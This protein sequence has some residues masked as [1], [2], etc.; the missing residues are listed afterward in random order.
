MTHF[1][2]KSQEKYCFIQKVNVEV[3]T[4]FWMSYLID[5]KKVTNEQ[6]ISIFNELVLMSSNKNEE[7]YIFEFLIFSKSA[8]KKSYHNNASYTLKDIALNFEKLNT[9]H[10]KMKV[11]EKESKKH[12]EVFNTM[13]NEEFKNYFKF[14]RW[15]NH[16]S[17]SFEPE[18]YN[19]LELKELMGNI[20]NNKLVIRFTEK[21]N[22]DFKEKAKRALQIFSKQK[23]VDNFH[24]RNNHCYVSYD[25]KNYLK[26]WKNI[27]NNEGYPK[28]IENDDA[29]LRF[30]EKESFAI[31]IHDNENNTSGF[32]SSNESYISDIN[33]ARLYQS[34]ELARKAEKTL[35]NSGAIV[36]VKVKFEEVMHN[37]HN[38]NV[39]VLEKV[40]ST[41]EKEMLEASLDNDEMQNLAKKLLNLCQENNEKLKSELEK[42]LIQEN[43]KVEKLSKKQ[44]I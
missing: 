24:M 43:N 25:F 31:F 4:L 29:M 34:E 27:L 19:P 12:S 8:I 41:K 15:A 5:T 35:T 7:A 39:S 38:I 13:T 23:F 28:E 17:Y 18:P 3:Q 6:V 22:L 10:E 30:N 44:K 37:P 36:K 32:L 2:I 14:D 9:F 42:L 11:I 40:S 26:N 21:K 1:F 33:Q 20:V 16:F